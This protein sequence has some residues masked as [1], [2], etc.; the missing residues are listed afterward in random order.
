M[1]VFAAGFALGVAVSTLVI[2]YV[3]GDGAHVATLR[4]LPAGAP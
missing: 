1:K 3:I 4:R 2:S